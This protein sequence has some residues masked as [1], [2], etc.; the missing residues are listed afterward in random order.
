M[1]QRMLHRAGTWSD[2]SQLYSSVNFAARPRVWS[3]IHWQVV[4]LVHV[5]HHAEWNSSYSHVIMHHVSTHDCLWK[6]IYQFQR[7]ICH[8]LCYA[9][10][11]RLEV[12]NIKTQVVIYSRAENVSHDVT[13]SHRSR[14]KELSSSTT[15]RNAWLFQ[16]HPECAALHTKQPLRFHLM[17]PCV[18]CRRLLT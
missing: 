8:Q 9:F 12:R 3:F 10:A 18:Q 17:K 14:Q 1:T 7:R 4:A 15:M 6:P 16:C 11:I 5:T 2:K 13:F